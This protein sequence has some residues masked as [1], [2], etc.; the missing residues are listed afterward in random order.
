MKQI[1]IKT[2]VSDVLAHILDDAGNGVSDDAFVVK[3]STYKSNSTEPSHAV[4]HIE[5][6]TVFRAR[7]LLVDT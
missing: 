7:Y 2:D 1:S 5:A 6:M 3:G 4:P